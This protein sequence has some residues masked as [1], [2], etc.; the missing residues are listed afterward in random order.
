M[1]CSKC[2]T[3]LAQNANFCSKCGMR[4]PE[5]YREAKT[6]PN[7]SAP[8]QDIPAQDIPAQDTPIQDTPIQDTPIQD[9]PMQG[10]TTQNP[11]PKKKL[12][13]MALVGFIVSMAAIITF[14]LAGGI[15]G[16]TLS[17]KGK[18]EIA[19]QDLDGLGFAKAGIS[20]GIANIIVGAVRTLLIILLIYILIWETT[21]SMPFPFTDH[22]SYYRDAETAVSMI[23]NN[24]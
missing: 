13:V 7:E 4:I 18:R 20:V 22:Y 17:R 6:C 3:E 2:G 10:T 24:F 12:S 5:K 8:P 9:T 11:A 21:S 16:L 23:V 14:P 19:E 1:F 15:V